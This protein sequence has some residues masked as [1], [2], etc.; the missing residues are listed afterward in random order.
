LAAQKVGIKA[1]IG[2]ELTALQGKFEVVSK[3]VLLLKDQFERTTSELSG[4]IEA[5]TRTLSEKVDESR[6]SILEKVEIL[7]DRKFLRVVGVVI[8]AIPV[9]YGGVMFLQGKGLGANVIAFIAM[10]IGVVIIL[11]TYSLSRRG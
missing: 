3:D 8:G 4:K 7:F 1:H 10:L 9:M 2:A 5:E 11:V 6:K